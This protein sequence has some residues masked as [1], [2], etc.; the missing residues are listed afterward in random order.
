M[1]GRAVSAWGRSCRLG[2]H[3]RPRDDVARRN[4]VFGRHG[5]TN[6]R[7][8][9]PLLQTVAGLQRGKTIGPEEISWALCER[10]KR[11]RKEGERKG[12]G[13]GLTCEKRK[14]IVEEKEAARLDS[15]SKLRYVVTLI[16]FSSHFHLNDVKDLI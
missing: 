5:V 7:A 1:G 8:A 15:K 14:K 2:S 11:K 13:L 6:S 4:V 9:M 16:S 3:A 12:N 10:K